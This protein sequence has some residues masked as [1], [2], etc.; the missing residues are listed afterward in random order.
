[1]NIGVNARIGPAGRA[2]ALAAGI[3]ICAAATLALLYAVGITPS[4]DAAGPQ[5]GPRAELVGSQAEL[6]ITMPLEPSMGSTLF[7]LPWGDKPGQVGLTQRAE[8]Q[9]RGPEAFAL[10]PDGRVAVLDSV[11][12]RL[13]LLAPSGAS[14]ATAPVA[15]AAP[16]F[17]A[18]NAEEVFVLDADEDLVL[19]TY[20]WEGTLLQT[21]PVGPFEEPVTSLLLDPQGRPLIETGHEATAAAE[22][23]APGN[24]APTG[25]RGEMHGRPVQAAPGRSVSTRMARGGA[26]RVEETG[27]DGSSARG[28]DIALGRGARI[29][30]MVSLDTDAQGRILLGL[31][32][33]PGRSASGAV[34]QGSGSAAGGATE[35]ATGAAG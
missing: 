2:A 17:L 29:D 19:L 16:R 24:A 28:W 5:V 3:P 31:R 20:S 33:L 26:P 11:N 18:A 9:S 1:M 35:S 13:L 27:P 6:L 12:S 14:L 21:L 10:A 7:T 34:R 25:V 32:V 23:W 30:H 8:E 22:A 15:L 4:A